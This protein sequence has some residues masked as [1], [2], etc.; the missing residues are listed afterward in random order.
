MCIEDTFLSG[1]GLGGFVVGPLTTAGKLSLPQVFYVMAVVVSALVL[2]FRVAF[3]FCQKYEDRMV[4]NRNKLLNQQESEMKGLSNSS[5][6]PQE[7][8]A[9]F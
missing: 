4:E 8:K 7:N 5:H 9:R 3:N 2:A 6:E 1:S